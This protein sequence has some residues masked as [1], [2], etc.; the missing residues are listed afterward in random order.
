MVRCLK[1]IVENKDTSW[2]NA[3]IQHG[4]KISLDKYETT[5]EHKFSFTVFCDNLCPMTLYNN[6]ILD[7]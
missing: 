6:P 7:K 1:E 3:D 5:P 4:Q 2:K